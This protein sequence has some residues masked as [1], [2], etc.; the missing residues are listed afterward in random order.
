MNRLRIELRK[1]MDRID[2]FSL[3]ERALIFLGVLG[4]MYFGA[5]QLVIQPLGQ[6]RTRLEQ[7]LKSKRDQIQT[8]EKQI[9]AML[10]GDVQDADGTKRARLETLRGQMK[11]MEAE[12]GKT[13]SGLVTPKEMARMVEAFLASKRGLEVVKVENLPPEPVGADGT[14]ANAAPGTPAPAA[15][16]Y[17]HGLR[18]ELRGSYLDMVRYLKGLEAQPWKVFWGQVSFQTEK[19][20]V[21]KLTLV[22]YT[23]STREGW[24]GI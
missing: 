13:T 20:P 11:T 3:R 1:L 2:E 8:T 4:L 9:Q 21:S 5:M 22:I 7:E 15:L 23:L 17:R 16:L 10:T 19:Y 6:Q 12:L 14:T 18:I 24:I